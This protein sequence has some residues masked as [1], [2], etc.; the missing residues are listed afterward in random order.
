LFPAE[1]GKSLASRADGIFR[2][3]KFQGEALIDL[4]VTSGFA[5]A[6]G[7][8]MVIVLTLR[9]LELCTIGGGVGS[10]TGPNGFDGEAR[11]Y[12]EGA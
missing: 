8:G 6:P 3:D 1:Q 4:R 10:D 7:A 2:K 11:P 12:W 5:G 9:A